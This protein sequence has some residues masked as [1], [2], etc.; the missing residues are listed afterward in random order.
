MKLSK[1]LN[2]SWIRPSVTTALV[3]FYM[4]VAGALPAVAQDDVESYKFDFG[5]GLG[6][7]GYLGDVNTS[8]LYRRPGVTANASFRYLMDSRWAFRGLLTASQLSGDSRDF[9]E[10]F[11]GGVDYKFK[12][13]V[14]D[15]GGRVEFNFFNYGIGE[16]YKRLRRWTPYLSLGLGVAMS[17][18]EGSTFVAA[19]LP[20]GVG[21]KY[22]INRRLNLGAEFTMTKAFGDHLDGKELDDLYQIKSS[23]LKNT[24]WYSTLTVSISYEFGPRC[25]VCNRID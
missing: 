22:K 15:L 8:N 18:C 9:D 14:F 10:V 17:S 2:I 11:P 16:T 19:T 25:V 12:S 4:L 7:S 5:G 23:F 6:L 24:D 20:M 21:V 13:W 1:H 3:A